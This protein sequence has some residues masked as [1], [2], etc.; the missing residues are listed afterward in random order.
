MLPQLLLIPGL[1]GDAAMWQ[2]QQP[3]LPAALR[4]QVATAHAGGASIEDMA[5]QLLAAHAGALLLCGASMGCLLYTSPSP[6]D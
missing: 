6:R 4:P 5:A 2:A 3:A 1:A